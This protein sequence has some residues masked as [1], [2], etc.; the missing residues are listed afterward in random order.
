MLREFV[1]LVNETVDDG[2]SRGIE[3][4]LESLETDLAKDEV[5]EEHGVDTVLTH[6]YEE[7]GVEINAL[8]ESEDLENIDEG[9]L[10]AMLKEL[11]EDDSDLGDEE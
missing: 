9:K 7:A 5:F 11:E 4:F 3:L 1:D 8:E 10:D 6:L 2:F